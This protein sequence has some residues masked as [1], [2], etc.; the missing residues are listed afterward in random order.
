MAAGYIQEAYY[1]Y[2]RW[3]AMAKIADFEK[4]TGLGLSISRQSQ[5]LMGE[6]LLVCQNWARE[7][8]LRSSCL[9]RNNLVDFAQRNPVS[10]P[11]KPGSKKEIGLI[12][13]AFLAL[14][15]GDRATLL[16][17]NRSPHR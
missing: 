7:L 3:G 16:R 8:S 17:S 5:W 2:S 12:L 13:S 1:A 10:R 14:D 4:G 15:A 9:W 11:K 6:K